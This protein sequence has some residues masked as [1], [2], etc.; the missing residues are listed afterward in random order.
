MSVSRRGF[1][2]GLGVGRTSHASAFIAARGHEELVA[3]AMQQQGRQGGGMRR[4][5]LPPGV[6][7]H[8]H[9]QQ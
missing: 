7:S 6:R 9:Q 4:P 3:E 8:S 5:A 1:L 2:Q